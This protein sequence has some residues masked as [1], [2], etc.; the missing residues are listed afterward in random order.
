MK[1]ILRSATDHDIPAIR[2][3][4]KSSFF[5]SDA[6]LDLFFKKRFNPLYTALY[7][8]EKEIAGMVHLLPCKVKDHGKAFYW[9]AV[10]VEPKYRGKHIF[11]KMSEEILR[12]LKNKGYISVCKPVHG[13]E[14]VYRK[15]GF[16]FSFCAKDLK[17]AR[18]NKNSEDMILI[19]EADIID[20]QNANFPS[21]SLLW[22]ENDIEYAI[23][24]NAF[25]GG[26]SLKISVEG[27]E[28]CAL[29]VLADDHNWYLDSTNLTA[30][31]A[32]KYG[33]SICEYL[34]T[35]FFYL[36]KP[37]SPNDTDS[38]VSG[39]CDHPIANENSELFFTLW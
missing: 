27:R 16:K 35:D 24:E 14:D 22:K 15:I 8:F 23:A 33:N 31:F 5:D 26:K 6:Y 12:S 2:S 3:L 4:W 34:N 9:Y 13:L 28:A 11:K 1:E 38:F 36:R 18:T 32:K 21:G 10:C 37:T 29:A 39:L 7:C 30:E 25:C 17:I 20:F 19:S